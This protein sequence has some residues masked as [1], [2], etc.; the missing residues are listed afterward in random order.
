MSKRLFPF[1][2]SIFPSSTLASMLSSP[3]SSESNVGVSI[4]CLEDNST[5]QAVQAIR[6]IF[7]IFSL[8]ILFLN[9]IPLL[10]GFMLLEMG[11]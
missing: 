11:S 5:A 6:N 8:N 1:Q 10:Q 7:L 3:I 4:T 9:F 2:S